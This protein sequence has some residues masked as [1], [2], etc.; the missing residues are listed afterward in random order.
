M[1]I[2]K[3]IFLHHGHAHHLGFDLL[4]KAGQVKLGPWEFDC[5]FSRSLTVLEQLDHWAFCWWKLDQLGSS[6]GDTILTFRLKAFRKDIHMNLT[7]L[8]DQVSCKFVVSRIMQHA[9]LSF[10]S[11]R[12]SD[13][14]IKSKFLFKL[15]LFCLIAAGGKLYYKSRTC[16]RF[17]RRLL[18][19]I[20]IEG[21]W[22]KSK[23][24]S[25]YGSLLKS[26]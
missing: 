18:G 17:N 15:S 11:R 3:K 24:V 20:W 16:L 8:L 5:G 1:P 26:W 7:S 2:S 23:K 19:Q 12:E 25:W 10:W 14:S 6:H 21:C 9:L 22:W 13:T 4:W